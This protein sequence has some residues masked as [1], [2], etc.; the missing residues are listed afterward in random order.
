LLNIFPSI[1]A[2]P[3]YKARE[4]LQLGLAEYY[5]KN[6]DDHPDAAGIVKH[7]AATIRKFGI[8][9]DQVGKMELSLLHVATANTIPTLYWLIA[10]IITGPKLVQ[11]L[12]E[13]ATAVMEHGLDGTVAIHV[14][15]LAE[16]CPLL[17][18]CYRETIRINNKALGHR[19]VM[20]DTTISDGRG[21]TYLLK[22]GVDVQTPADTL[23]M[24]ESAWGP[25]V[26]EF[27]PDRFLE[28]SNNLTSE[29]IKARRV[30]YVPF[31]GGRHLCPGRN[32]AFAENLGFMVTFL[33]GYEVSPLDGNWGAF[34]PPVQD[35]CA[36]ADAVCKPVN[37]GRDLGM[38][39]KRRA[40]WES[41]K[42]RFVVGSPS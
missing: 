15:R 12:R 27:N 6:G 41:T 2:K 21:R 30:S 17:V 3:T 11:R 8:I 23:H 28:H 18:S 39:F 35:K 25:D 33:L 32:F 42:W 29:D 20:A 16:K 5:S 4:R 26:R 34:K 22:K 37:N 10:F 1:I 31:G 36:L 9:G 40:G 13:E 19:R 7:R 38:K 14:D 24:A